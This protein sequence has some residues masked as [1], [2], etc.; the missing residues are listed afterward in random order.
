MAIR[1][2]I[3]AQEM[4]PTIELVTKS[5]SE[6]IGSFIP[7]NYFVSNFFSSCA[8]DWMI[9]TSVSLRERP[10]EKS[11]R[12]SKAGMVPSVAMQDE[13]AVCKSKLHG[14]LILRWNR[15]RNL[16]VLTVPLTENPHA[17]SF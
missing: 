9:G 3:L 8:S 5:N 4:R 17:K 11:G 12:M 1:P 2:S 15:Y 14:T 6:R 16:S 10:A 7:S 13:L